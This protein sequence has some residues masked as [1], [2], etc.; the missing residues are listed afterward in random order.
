MRLH[1]F[2]H[3]SFEG[4][5][6]IAEWAKGKDVRITRFYEKGWRIPEPG[7]Y[8]LLVVMG[9]P[10]GVHDEA[11]YDWLAAEKAAI[12]AAVDAGK[13][14]LGVCLGAQLAA[15]VLGARVAQGPHKEIGWFP[16]QAVQ[17]HALTDALAGQKVFHWHGDTFAI[18]D[19]A[20]HLLASEA[21]GTQAFL[22]RGQVLGLQFHI[23]LR[24]QDVEGL[25]AHGGDE[26]EAGG[27]FVQTPEQIRG[28]MSHCD[29]LRPTLFSMLDAFALR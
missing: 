26:L 9:G 24:A 18:P 2:Q 21:C 10:M 1:I 16:L 20:V 3:V 29:A 5:G 28:Q 13:K 8:D 12:R 4:P 19:G 23:E 27:K 15:H 7:A 11:R 6:A 14:V 25:L 22:W 17:R